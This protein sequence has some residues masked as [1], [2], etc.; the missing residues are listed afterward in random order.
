M[1]FKITRKTID[2]SCEKLDHNI[3]S[4]IEKDIK[5]KFEKTCIEDYGVVV[6]VEKINDISNIICRDPTNIIFTVDFKSLFFKPE[7]GLEIIFKPTTII[8]RGIFGKMYEKISIFIPESYLT[9]WVFNKNEECFNHKKTKKNIRKNID[10]SAIIV[11]IKYDITKYN[12]ICNL[13]E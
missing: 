3:L 11:D 6:S 12:C 9:E 5:S 8:S 2:L 10:L 7:I 13:N 1:E 4:T